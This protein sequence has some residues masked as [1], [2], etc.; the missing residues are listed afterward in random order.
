MSNEELV[1]KLIMD[2]SGFTSGLQGAIKKLGE[3]D[4]KVDNSSQKGGRSLGNI[5][6][7]FVGNFLASG[8]SKIIS[9]GIGM[10]T[11]SID[12]AINRVDTLNNST[13]V[14]ENMGFGIG[15]VESTMESLK[16]SINGLPTPLDGAIKGLQLIASSTNDLSKSE[17]IFSALN[18]GILGFGGSA[19]MVDNAIIQLSQAFS[20]GKVDAQTWN[21][22]INSGMGPALN[23]LAKQMGI[24]TG[25]FKEGLSDGSISV[26]SFQDSL[27]KLNKE[28][29]GG[30]KSLEQIAQDST[31]G[32][33]TGLANMKTAVTRGIAN[34]IT[35]LDEGLQSAG[36]GS[37]SEIIAEKGAQFESML[38]K[39]ADAIPGILKGAKE[40]YDTLEPYAP[41]FVGLI[42]GLTTLTAVLKIQSTI[43]AVSEAF[44][45]WK[46][47]TE[48]VTIAQKI[49]NSTIL[50]NPIALIIT[51][52]VALTAGF[53]YLWKTNED[54]R[55]AVKQIWSNITD[56]ISKA[57]EKV[58]EMWNKTM[59]FFGN[60]WD[61]VKEGF[62]KAGEWMQEAPGK[63]ADAIKNKWDGVKT[64]FS[65]LWEDVKA[66]AV[67]VWES[68]INPIQRTFDKI[69]TIVEP[70][71]TSVM[72]IFDDL[73]TYL[74]VLW[75]NLS[76][77][78]SNVWTIIKNVILAPVLFV[79]SLITGGWE[80]A[81]NNMIGVWNNIASAGGEIWESIK[82]I[83]VGWWAFISDSAIQY[84]NG[85]KDTIIN[86]WNVVK[87]GTVN[88]WTSLK[89]WLS[90]TWTSIKQF[91]SDTWDGLKAKTKQTWID[92]KQGVVDGWTG[93]K[94]FFVDTVTG[95]I[96]RAQTAWDDLKSGVSKAIEKVKETFNKLKEINLFD[97]GKNI[98]QGLVDGIG[99]KIGAIGNKIK[100]IATTI[101]DGIKGE[102]EIFSPSRWMKRMIGKNIPLGVVEG[103]EDEQPTLDDAVKKMADLPTDLPVIDL[104]NKSNAQSND[105]VATTNSNDVYN[106]TLQTFGDLPEAQMMALAKQ[107]VK[108][109]KEVKDRED[110]PTGG[111]FGGI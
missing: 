35:G 9:S 48:G 59:E 86:V 36:F 103:I 30:L 27:I 77:I 13:R 10:I 24:T 25:A 92:I 3:F 96:T 105:E 53:I 12:S 45:K 6:T 17:E 22:M 70:I 69:Y 76:N 66:K 85:M 15:E 72:N 104:K 84:F 29:G 28:G 82:N 47:V 2:E 32:I 57:A 71:I 88:A 98:I 93:I 94:S 41:L 102:L 68:I 109:I 31:A 16:K 108:Y 49:L 78:A 52:I 91:A 34:V 50:S 90:D 67:S 97:I 107:F 58:V 21:S 18:N 89:Q 19:E 55:D 100:D 111:V 26:E 65:K 83:I 87:Q 11:S 8:A 51:A 33:K 56:F 81:K 74:E 60:M 42:A 62:T 14:F 95:M 101:K 38:N 99:E 61:G 37:I 23:A 7:S 5:W 80:E 63:A 44:K 75:T 64:F 73:K 43:N 39:V 1:L 46:T 4:G 79:T 20:N 54:F 106:V 40:L 110:A